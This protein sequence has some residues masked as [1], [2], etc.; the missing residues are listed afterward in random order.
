MQEVRNE[1]T[2]RIEALD[3]RVGYCL[4]Q[5]A[6]HSTEMKR[7]TG[8]LEHSQTLIGQYQQILDTL[9]IDEPPG[10]GARA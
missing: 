1:M 4:E 2:R 8:E 9:P 7:L 6:E 10:R 3:K 5:I